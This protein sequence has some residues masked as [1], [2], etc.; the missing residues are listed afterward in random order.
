MAIS[1]VVGS[2]VES[3]AAVMRVVGGTVLA[4]RVA[5]LTA[6]VE[7][8]ALGMMASV[9]VWKVVVAKRARLGTQEAEEETEVALSGGKGCTGCMR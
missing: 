5:A 7:G 9:A 2:A 8:M 4:A 1:L 3:K 6:V